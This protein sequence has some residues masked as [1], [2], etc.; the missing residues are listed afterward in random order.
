VEMVKFP[1]LLILCLSRLGAAEF[2]LTIG[3]PIAANIPRM[4]TAAIAVRLENCSDFAKAT[5][6]ATAEGLVAGVRRS[7]SLQTVAGA[8]PG[9]YAVAQSWPFDG[10]WVVNLKATCGSSAVGTIVPFRGTGFLRESLKSFPRFATAA[11]VDGSLS[12]QS[13]GKK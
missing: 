13:G 1:I 8:T 2:S 3:N 4:K 7:V 6:S 9:V 5:L 11:E 12:E 10:M